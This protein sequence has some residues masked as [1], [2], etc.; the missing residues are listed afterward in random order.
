MERND[1]VGSQ[2]RNISHETVGVSFPDTY[3]FVE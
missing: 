3:N 2:I 1:V